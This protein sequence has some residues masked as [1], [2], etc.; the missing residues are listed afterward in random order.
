MSQNA[1]AG[2]PT[3]VYTPGAFVW[4]ELQTKDTAKAE[5]FYT[6]LFGWTIKAV[7][8]GNM[9]YHLIHLGDKQIGGMMTVQ[10]EKL[11][12]FWT[13]Y[14]S[15]PDV[16]QAAASATA[17]GGQI[18]AGPM[19][20]PNVGRFAI[21]VDSLGAVVALFKSVHGDPL[22]DRPESGEFCWDHL[23]TTD[24]AASTAYYEKVVGW[25]KAEGDV[26]KYGDL[27]EA[28]FGAA[29]EG[30]PPSWVTHI[31]IPDLAAA[32]QKAAGLGATILMSDVPAGEFGRFSVIQD[33]T[34]GV[35]ALFQGNE[36]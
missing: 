17:A 10:D 18:V 14:V 19:D 16:D 11:P 26:F 32:T 34:G 23:N 35:F 1:T 9:M 8:M 31:V 15:V 13:G 21:S 36:G 27:M 4:H 20:I 2:T 29:P 6:A 12:S 25:Q 24:A 33:P 7:D 5:T 3:A 30:V 28:S 22:T